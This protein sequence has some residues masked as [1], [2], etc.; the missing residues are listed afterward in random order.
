MELAPYIL[1]GR[2]QD[3]FDPV[4]R[5]L[6]SNYVA[7]K[8]EAD[9][10]ICSVIAVLTMALDRVTFLSERYFFEFKRVFGFILTLVVFTLRFQWLVSYFET[11]LGGAFLR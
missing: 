11:L 8:F 2:F 4:V 3:L 1:S 7:Q 6:C 5:F 9:L 10:F